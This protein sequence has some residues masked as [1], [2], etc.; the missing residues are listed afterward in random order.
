M[1]LRLY[2]KDAYQKDFQAHVTGCTACENGYAVTL[3]QTAF[4][5]EGG[6]QPCDLGTLTA[7][8]EQILVTDLQ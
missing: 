7:E 4:Y 1:T 5:P 6:G 8:N 2:Y 3:D